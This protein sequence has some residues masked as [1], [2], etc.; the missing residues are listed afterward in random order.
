MYG[1]VD[2]VESLLLVGGSKGGIFSASPLCRQTKN[3]A[4]PRQRLAQMPIRELGLVHKDDGI[5]IYC[6]CVSQQVKM[7]F[8]DFSG[9]EGL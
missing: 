3:R 6:V 2:L 7:F 9:C 5:Q 4:P 1:V 8:L